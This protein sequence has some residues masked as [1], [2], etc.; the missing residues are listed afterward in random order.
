M[1]ARYW[2]ESEIKKPETR[3]WMLVSSC[4]R[5]VAC[6]WFL[7]TSCLVLVSGVGFRFYISKHVLTG[8][9]TSGWKSETKA[10][11]PVLAPYF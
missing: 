1:V 4:L 8:L 7:D 3:N 9:A 11:R 2:L 10:N 5:L 6:Y